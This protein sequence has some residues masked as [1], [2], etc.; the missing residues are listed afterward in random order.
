MK[1]ILMLV[2]AL[3][4]MGSVSVSGQG[5]TIEAT[6]MRLSN[7]YQ[8]YVTFRTT[9]NTGRAVVAWRGNLQI[10]NP[11]GDLIWSAQLIFGDESDISPRG[12]D[13]SEQRLMANHEQ[14]FMQDGLQKGTYSLQDYQFKDLRFTWSNVQVAYRNE[15]K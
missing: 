2:V 11:F 10:R 6:Q 9:N 5:V 8:S 13:L 15:Y 4:A 3:M 14:P 7:T 12:T 1:K